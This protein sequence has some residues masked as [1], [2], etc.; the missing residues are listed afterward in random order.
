MQENTP[1]LAVRC[2]TGLFLP[3]WRP[4]FVVFP[5]P[6]VPASVASG[7][8]LSLAVIVS[9]GHF[10]LLLLSVSPLPY[11][12]APVLKK[13]HSR[14]NGEPGAWPRTPAPNLLAEWPGLLLTSLST[15]GCK[16]DISVLGSQ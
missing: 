11:P 15:S 8:L 5:A 4:P 2:W 10:H 3:P 12:P 13:S 16:C 9:R 6:A 14:E 1:G 7:L